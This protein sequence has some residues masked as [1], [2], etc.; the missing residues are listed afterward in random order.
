MEDPSPISARE[1]TDPAAY[2]NRRG[3][4]R[5]GIL[6]ASAA[7][8]GLVYRRLNPVGMGKVDTPL[9]QGLITPSAG[10]NVTG[11]RVAEPATSLR[12]ITPV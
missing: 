1:I 11:F 8:T 5:A 12:A 4:I 3:F 7:A 10:E 9:I 2:S 6:A